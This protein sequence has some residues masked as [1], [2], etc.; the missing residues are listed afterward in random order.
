MTTAM[1][2]WDAPPTQD[3][4]R[5]GGTGPG[6]AASTLGRIVAF[7]IDWVIIAFVAWL[8]TL[9]FSLIHLSGVGALLG[10]AVSLGYW[11]YF[12]GSTGQTIGNRVMHI[13]TVTMSGDQLGYGSAFL[14]GL[15]VDLSFAICLV[16]AII[17][18]IMMAVTEKHQALH[19]LILGTTVVNA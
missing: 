16:P 4:F 11:T 3:P 18:L 14:R 6:Q 8:V 7:V 2:T 19:D 17:S 5:V 10:A 13:R 15:L 9:I 1:G 12:W